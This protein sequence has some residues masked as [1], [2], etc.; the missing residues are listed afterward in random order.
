ML[1]AL[2]PIKDFSLKEIRMLVL[3]AT[4]IGAGRQFERPAAARTAARRLAA[5]NA[6]D[7]LT[8]AEHEALL[9]WNAGLNYNAIAERTGRPIESVGT[10][11]RCARERLALADDLIEE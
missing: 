8:A 4:L 10:I 6:L 3:S 7:A 9:L 11:L 2:S 5:I 1:G